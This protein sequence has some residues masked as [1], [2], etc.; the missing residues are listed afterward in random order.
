M[1]IAFFLPRYHSNQKDSISALV[2]KKHLVD[3]YVQR[4]GKSELY[5][6]IPKVLKPSLFTIIVHT[7][8]KKGDV[9]LKKQRYFIPS[10]I[11]LMHIPRY[12][13]L[14]VFRDRSLMT[15][16]L[17]IFFKL[18]RKKTKTILYNQSPFYGLDYTYPFPLNVI[19]K[20]M[21]L[22]TPRYRYTTVLGVPKYNNEPHDNKTFF[23]P[24]V[25]DKQPKK[26]QY[27]NFDRINILSIGKFT[28][29]KNFAFLIEHLKKHLLSGEIYLTLVGEVTTK[30]HTKIYEKIVS[31]ISNLNLRDYI[32]ILTN[33]PY[34]EM[35]SIY[36][37]NDIFI[38]A[39]RNEPAAYS[40][41]EAMAHALV[42]IVSDQNGTN[43]LIEN[44]AS[45][46]IFSLSDQSL[47]EIIEYLMLN[48]NKIIDIANCAYYRSL[49][50]F[51][52]KI[53]EEKILA[54]YNEM[55]KDND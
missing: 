50:K 44:K 6:I 19:K 18:F 14:C 41:L 17:Y 27:F 54:I 31:L 23:I 39:S 5:N 13:D 35:S 2:E 37:S 32:N 46:F 8:I 49:T 52:K 22:L 30:E 16:T 7:F 51:N 1:K 20:I 34:K 9:F 53:Y 43:Y 47:N 29:R 15:A 12:Y 42:P 33:I 4:F 26:D 38:L 36:L 48:K 45:G 10:F 40:P 28:E 3:V 11:C 25:I 24:F 55:V 21:I